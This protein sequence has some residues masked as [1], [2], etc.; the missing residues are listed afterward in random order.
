M[1]NAL[2]HEN[3]SNETRSV[4]MLEKSWKFFFFRFV[5]F[6]YHYSD[7]TR[8]LTVVYTRYENKDWKRKIYNNFCVQNLFV[9]TRY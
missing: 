9:L 6:D 5:S 3:R 2:L 7:G 1:D 4:G 8:V